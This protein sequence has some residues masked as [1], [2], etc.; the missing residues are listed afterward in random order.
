MN[1]SICIHSASIS[2]MTL[3]T[4]WVVENTMVRKTLRLLS[5]GAIPERSTDV[6]R[7]GDPT[8]DTCCEGKN[9]KHRASLP[10][11]KPRNQFKA[12]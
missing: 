4:A 3:D 7:G 5:G 1:S 10:H 11:L 2:G 6:G 9:G 8:K 12:G